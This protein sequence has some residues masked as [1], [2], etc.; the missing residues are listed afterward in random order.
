MAEP[1]VP[2]ARVEGEVAEFGS[3]EPGGYDPRSR[4][5]LLQWWLGPVAR[6]KE[7][8]SAWVGYDDEGLRFYALLED[9]D[10]T[11]RATAD[12]QRLWE[13][14]DVVEFFVKPREDRPEYYETHLDPAGHM[15]D[16]Y[17]ESREKFENETISWEDMVDF[18][19][20]ASRRVETFPERSRWAAELRTPWRTYG[21]ESPPAPGTRWRFAVCRYD[22]SSRHR[23][24]VD[25]PELSSTAHIT[26]LS[27]HRHDEWH[28]LV[29]E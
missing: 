28:E 3:D 29:F 27:F 17:V 12:N 24:G 4:L 15:M 11:T 5:P 23:S 13:L 26:E 10:M 16:L 22:Y 14:G 1:A 25:E 8:A 21:C 20:F 18:E 9:S 19:S 7:A 2:C 6:P